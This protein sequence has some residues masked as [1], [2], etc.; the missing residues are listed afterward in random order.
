MVYLIVLMLICII[1]LIIL[2]FN[3]RS[4]KLEQKTER[5]NFYSIVDNYLLIIDIN[6]NILDCNHVFKNLFFSNQEKTSF[7]L[8]DF[9]AEEDIVVFKNNI[10]QLKNEVTEKHE[11][12]LII[13]EKELIV[14]WTMTKN[15]K[16][17]LIY[18]SGKD[19]TNERFAYEQLQQSEEKSR[20]QFKS[21][22]IPT[23]TW[24]RITDDFVLTDYNDI[25]YSETE[26]KVQHLL[27]INANKLLLHNYEI[28][29]DMDKCYITRSTIKKEVKYFLHETN[30]YKYYNVSYAFVP[31]DTVMV[32]MEDSTRRKMMEIEIA[33]NEEKYR[34]LFNTT[35]DS[36]LLV[37]TDGD[38][39]EYNDS[40]LKMFGFTETELEK[41]DL[42]D[43]IK[44]IPKH[45]EQNIITH[46][47]EFIFELFNKSIVDGFVEIICVKKNQETFPAEVQT[48]FIKIKENNILLLF[49]RDISQRKL[50]EKALKDSEAQLRASF[51]NLPFDFWISD[52]K[53]NILMQS[54]FSI[55]LWGSLIGKNV[56]DLLIPYDLKTH[57]LAVSENALKGESYNSEISFKVN[58]E[59]RTFMQMVLP[60]ISEKSIYGILN[61]NIDI[62]DA[63][64]KELELKKYSDNLEKVNHELKTF[65][66][67]ISHDLKAP[68]R[69]I[70][71]LIEWISEDYSDLFDDEGRNMLSLLMNRASRMHELIESILKY[72]RIGRIE[73]S[74][75]ETDLNEL[76]QATVNMLHIPQNIKVEI[77]NDLPVILVPRIYL[78]QIFQNLLSN[79][80]KFL[81]KE[82]G[83]IE[84]GFEEL[85]YDYKFWVK[86]NGVGIESQY[87]SKIFQLFQTLQPRDEYEST[88]IGLSIVK[89]IIDTYQGTIWVESEKNIGTTFYFTFPKQNK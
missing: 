45:D 6:G 13:Q 27:G 10:S 60:V 44:I 12:K 21:V 7:N 15:Q 26:G 57:I 43:I 1:C 19:N 30:E 49:I 4:T 55:D 33:E 11:T 54:K 23:Y 46:V 75:D 69:A 78:Q 89:K 81:D 14:L 25:V 51:E 53:L 84:I 2:F 47:E 59:D 71:N 62:S 9:I 88:G 3:W 17:S 76:I 87:Y 29:K 31:P 65:T 68:L 61:I 37:N 58:E 32:H 28:L 38:I 85:S 42:L 22:P 82:N 5:M 64:F 40:S 52:Q 20:R 39:L 48:Q 16:Y 74:F 77:Y 73:V 70:N 80:I 41:I 35:T 56:N 79:A 66:Y 63:K 8:F 86:D 83:F 72:S 50:M 67:I 34:T 36:I 24:K 18:L